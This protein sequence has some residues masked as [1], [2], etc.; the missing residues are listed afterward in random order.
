M[1]EVSDLRVSYGTTRA[2]EGLDLTVQRGRALALLGPNGAGKS[3]TL[4]AI[5]GQVRY[6]G[7]IRFDGDDLARSSPEQLARRGIIQVPEGRRLFGPLTVRENLQTGEIAR[8]GRTAA[9]SVDDV[10]DLFPPLRP[11]RDRAGF[12]LSGGE[13]QMVAVGRALVAAP[14][15]LLVDEPTLGLAPAI[16]SVVMDVLGRVGDRMAVVIVEQ[17]AAAALAVVTDAAVV[18]GGRVVLAGEAG[19]IAA[20]RDLLSSYLGR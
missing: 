9:Y 19:T 14:E 16:A 8:A 4:R 6:E 17:A 11:L 5:S 18:R 3:S 15:L 10:F 12:A 1:L 20:D 13:Q 2:V 7:S